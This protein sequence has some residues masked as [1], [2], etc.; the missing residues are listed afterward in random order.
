[1]SVS[2]RLLISQTVITGIIDALQK[3]GCNLTLFEANNTKILEEFPQENRPPV[4]KTSHLWR[5]KFL[6]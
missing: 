2:G 1:M 4:L 5:E 3:G 6:D